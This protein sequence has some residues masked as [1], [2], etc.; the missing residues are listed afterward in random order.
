MPLPHILSFASRTGVA[1]ESVLQSY[2]VPT[3][4]KKVYAAL[5]RCI[6]FGC[7]SEHQCGQQSAQVVTET[8]WCSAAMRCLPVTST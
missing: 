3:K 1:I 7:P 5:H 2:L 4:Q 6:H 8:G